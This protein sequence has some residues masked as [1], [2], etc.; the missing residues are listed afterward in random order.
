MNEAKRDKLRE[1]VKFLDKASSIVDDVCMAEQ[2]CMDNM[3]EN[4]QNSERFE[5][6]EE[7]VDCLSDALDQISE[8][9]ENVLR[10]ISG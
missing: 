4:L 7:G 1:A 2:D 6:M 10:A 9:R 8:A 3:P 5:Q